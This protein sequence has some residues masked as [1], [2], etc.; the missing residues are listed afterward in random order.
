MPAGITQYVL[1]GGPCDGNTGD[2]TPAIDSSGRIQCGGH[3]YDR[4]EPVQVVGGRELFKD[5]G[6][7]PAPPKPGVSPRAHKAW[8]HLQHAVNREWPA[9]LKDS[10]RMTS[11]ALRALARTHK[12]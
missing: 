8:A 3:N 6:A 5:A 10:G 9:T 12:V 2:L 11:A 1:Q 4:A 7:I